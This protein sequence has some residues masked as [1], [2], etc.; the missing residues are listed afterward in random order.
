[1]DQLE[2]FSIDLPLRLGPNDFPICEV[3]GRS[4]SIGPHKAT[5][6]DVCTRCWSP[7]LDPVGAASWDRIEAARRQTETVNVSAELL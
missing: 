7:V 6:L 3:C 2:L 4:E 5:R 1:M